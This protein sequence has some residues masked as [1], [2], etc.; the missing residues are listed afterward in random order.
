MSEELERL[1]EMIKMQNGTID[2]LLRKLDEAEARQKTHEDITRALVRHAEDT[3]LLALLREELQR[4]SG[5]HA[6]SAAALELFRKQIGRPLRPEEKAGGE[7]F[8]AE[9]RALHLQDAKRVLD[10]EI[11]SKVFPPSAQ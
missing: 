1:R 3:R 8:A 4:E 11:S 9:R 5:L 10:K 7:Q 2:F 6:N